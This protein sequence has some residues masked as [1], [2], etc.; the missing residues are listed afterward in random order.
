VNNQLD[1][2]VPILALENKVSLQEAIDSACDLVREARDLFE[3]A[4]K[5]L[6]ILTGNADLDE[7]IKRYAKACKD[8]VAGNVNWRYAS[9]PIIPY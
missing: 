6:P 5:R 8:I 1:S 9:S 2:I 4:E 3:D 7:Q